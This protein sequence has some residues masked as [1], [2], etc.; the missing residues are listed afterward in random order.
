MSLL[1]QCAY[2]TADN[3]KLKYMKLCHESL[4]DTVSLEDHPLMITNNSQYK[5]AIDYLDSF[6]KKHRNISVTHLKENIGTARGINKIIA[7]RGLNEPVIKMDDDWTT[8]HIDWVELMQSE[9][10][11]NPKIG[12][13]GLRRDDVYGELIEDGNLLWNA[14]V[15]GTCTMYNPL[16][17]NKIGSL[18]QFSEYGY[19]DNLYSARSEA[20]GFRNAFMK[21]IKITNLDEGGTDYTEWKKEE[22]G[23][24][25]QEASVMMDKIRKGE[26]GYYYPF[27]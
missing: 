11:T 5:E 10:E 7:Y 8:S 25:L 12:I 18:Q 22:A 6:A 2:S 16:L 17:I 13:L 1:A 19:D 9:I 14:D 20:A 26:L 4:L 23:F 27:D 21:N 3:G 24:Y 15:M